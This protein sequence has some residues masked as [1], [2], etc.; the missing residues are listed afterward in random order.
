MI[1]KIK[2][3]KIKS[4]MISKVDRNKF[5]NLLAWST[6]TND[7]E[8]SDVAVDKYLE[9]WAEAKYEFYI[10][11]GNNLKI[12][13]TIDIPISDTEM[14]GLV[15]DLEQRYPFHSVILDYFNVNDYKENKC[16]KNETLEK[17]CSEVYK[18]GMKL[19]KFLSKYFMDNKF[20]IEVSKVLQNKA[21][22]GVVTISID[23]MDYGFMSVN[24]NKWNSCYNIAATGYNV[25]FLAPLSAMMDEH[26]IV[27]YRGNTTEYDYDFYGK[28]I[29]YM[30]MNNRAVISIDKETDSFATFS[31][32]PC[33]NNVALKE[34]AEMTQGVIDTFNKAEKS[35]WKTTT[36]VII[37][38][39]K[40]S[41]FY[42]DFKTQYYRNGQK[43]A[44][45]LMNGVEKMICPV[46]GER[47]SDET[48]NICCN[49][50]KKL[51]VR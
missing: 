10:G 50:R 47:H 43:R 33:D 28:T 49:C 4:E 32:Q 23:P 27:C 8:V 15:D 20:D 25:Y 34:W 17:Y 6:H 46:C 3:K 29:R 1:A 40:W 39:T 48:K 12:S 16:P 42:H 30:S 7:V 19:S 11:M 26:I 51:G 5:K 37:R 9:E 14:R 13:K 45:N 44:K 18:P 24:K 41:H 36:D 22:K 38:D 35:V 2:L 31:P 21:N